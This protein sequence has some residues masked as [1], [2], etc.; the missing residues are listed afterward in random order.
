MA[1]ELCNSDTPKS[2]LDAEKKCKKHA[3]GL[4]VEESVAERKGDVAVVVKAGRENKSPAGIAFRES[5]ALYAE[6]R[7]EDSESNRCKTENGREDQVLRIGE[8]LVADDGV[9]CEARRK[10]GDDKPSKR[11]ICFARENVNLPHGIAQGHDDEDGSD[12]LK[13]KEKLRNHAWRSRKRWRRLAE[14][15]IADDDR[16]NHTG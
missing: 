10:Q 6:P 4:P 15:E 14:D 5:E 16:C 2:H 12:D 13:E 11:T 8:P 3:Q 9:K 7:D 1:G